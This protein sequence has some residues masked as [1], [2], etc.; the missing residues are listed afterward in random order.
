MQA[1]AAM[2][3]EGLLSIHRGRRGFVLGTGMS[4]SIV[5]DE[6]E[7]SPGV[8]S[9]E[10]VIGCKQTY[11]SFD[12]RYWVSMDPSYY[13]REFA[14][15]RLCPFLKFV[16]DVEGYAVDL[17]A[18][19]SLIRLPYRP[20]TQCADALP[21]D[22]ASLGIEADTGV[23]ALRLAYL[24]GLNPI[25]VLG[26]GDGIHRGRLHFHAE[27]K[28]NTSEAEVLS[29]GRDLFPLIEAMRAAGVDVFSCSPISRL[30]EAAPYVDIRSLGLEEGAA[31]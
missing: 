6:L 1:T 23:V 25:Y 20:G 26:L 14:K 28:R 15:I 27:S 9:Q 31:R 30:N 24:L 13:A 19:R 22:F 10:N 17:D 2:D 8:L 4:I 7:L 5:F 3:P 29:M 16:P 11:K 18:D 21:R 12:L